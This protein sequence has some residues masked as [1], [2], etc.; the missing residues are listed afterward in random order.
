MK[1]EKNQTTLILQ[2]ERFPKVNPKHSA[3]KGEIFEGAQA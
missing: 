2:A 3:K 1:A